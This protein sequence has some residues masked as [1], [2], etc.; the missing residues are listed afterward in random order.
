MLLKKIY[1]RL[2]RE[3]RLKKIRPYTEL[4]LDSYYGAGFSV[5][6]RDPQ[7]DRIYLST[8]KHCVLEGRYVFERESGQIRIGDR[9]HIGNSTFISI[10]EIRIDDDVTI[11]WDCLFY[12]HNSHSIHWKER[13]NVLDQNVVHGL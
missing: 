1:H 6:L 4:N 5:D 2:R 9:V 11:A 3:S 13:K 7:K 12:D 10:N 8:G